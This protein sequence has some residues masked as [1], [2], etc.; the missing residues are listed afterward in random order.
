LQPAADLLD[1]LPAGV[2]PA[3]GRLDRAE[4]GV[5][6]VEVELADLVDRLA[7]DGEQEPGGPDPRPL[8]VGAGVLDHHLV[9]P[10][11]HAGVRLAPLAVAAVV[12][13]DPPGDPA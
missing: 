6:L 9:E 4:E 2:G 7:G 8:A 1:H 3:A 12:P 5:Q 13:L 11:L 10:G